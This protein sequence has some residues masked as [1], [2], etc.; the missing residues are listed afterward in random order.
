MDITAI[1]EWLK[2][3]VPVAGVVLQVMG[4]CVIVASVIVKA[5]ES[6]SDDEAFAKLKAIPILGA[7]IIALE[8][9]SLFDRKPE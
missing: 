8:R 3:M 2:T 4:S 7:L 9:F 5:T 6:K 1:L